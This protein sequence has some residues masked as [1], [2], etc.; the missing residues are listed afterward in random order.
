[1]TFAVPSPTWGR[2]E[3]RFPSVPCSGLHGRRPLPRL[4]GPALC[5]VQE[6]GAS[7]ASAQL[8]GALR[9]HV[10][11][12]SR[13]LAPQ[14]GVQGPAAGQEPGE[15][16]AP[17]PGGT[18]GLLLLAAVKG[19]MKLNCAPYKLPIAPVQGPP[20]Q[21]RHRHRAEAGFPEEQRAPLSFATQARP[22]DGQ[23]QHH[24]GAISNAESQA[25]PS[26]PS[27]S[28][29]AFYQDQQEIFMHMKV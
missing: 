21:Q 29:S 23:D 19:P 9:G 18:F 13:S 3:G 11:S 22:S 24:L 26:E 2:R 17:P 20:Q 6:G 25:P 7:P 5:R 12:P 16:Q 10:L 1:M 8:S 4:G 15:L 14:D 27:G 28:G